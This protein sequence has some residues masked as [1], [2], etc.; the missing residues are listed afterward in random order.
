MSDSEIATAA[1]AVQMRVTYFKE[2][3][4]PLTRLGT[5]TAGDVARV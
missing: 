4:E 3:A 1:R 5:V 2:L